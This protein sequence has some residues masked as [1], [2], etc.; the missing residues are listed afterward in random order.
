[1]DSNL[2]I[3]RRAAIGS[4]L[5]CLCKKCLETLKQILNVRDTQIFVVEMTTP[6][7][8]IDAI[9]AYWREKKQAQR[10]A[11]KKLVFEPHITEFQRCALCGEWHPTGFIL[12]SGRYSRVSLD[13]YHKKEVILNFVRGLQ[14]GLPKLA[15]FIDGKT[16]MS[17][18]IKDLVENEGYAE[19][20]AKEEAKTLIQNDIYRTK[21]VKFHHDAA[22]LENVRNRRLKMCM[23]GRMEMFKETEN[24]ARAN[25]MNLLEDPLF[26]HFPEGLV[27][28]PQGRYDLVGDVLVPFEICKDLEISL[29]KNPTIKALQ[30]C[31][32]AKMKKNPD[33]DPGVAMQE[34]MSELK[35]T[36]HGEPEKQQVGD[37]YGKSAAEIRA[38]SKSKPDSSLTVGNIFGL[39]RK[40]RLRMQRHGWD[41]KDNEAFEQCVVEK[42]K[43][44]KTRKEAE[45]L[46]EAL[47]DVSTDSTL[48]PA[49]DVAGQA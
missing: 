25:C 9:R 24:I 42:M 39:T 19:A 30:Q 21:L 43:E 44:G 2:K 13:S 3:F 38:M 7:E 47:S 49:G 11:K 27:K 5:R 28:D 26:R 33:L 40:Q 32:T 45:D 12:A 46:C 18:C 23:L 36:E 1:M 16:A 6:Q 17:L 35:S 34:C 48:E 37:L 22:V 41:Q 8:K 29:I 14:I 10:A 31:F 15:A 4:F 20:A